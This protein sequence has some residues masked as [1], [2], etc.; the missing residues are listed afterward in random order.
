M[1]EVKK[2]LEELLLKDDEVTML[3]TNITYVTEEI[4]N[5][6]LKKY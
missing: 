2:P 6:L 5:K 4:L 1:H 3:D